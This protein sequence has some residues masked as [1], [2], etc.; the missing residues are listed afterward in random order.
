MVDAV[1]DKEGR[2][3]VDSVVDV[4][5]QHDSRKG[6]RTQQ[7]EPCQPPADAPKR[8]GA[9]ER[10][11]RV[12]GKKLVR[13]EEGVGDGRAEVAYIGDLG[14]AQMRHQRKRRA[15]EYKE[16]HRVQGKGDAVGVGQKHHDAY[17]HNRERAVDK[18]TVDL[19]DGDIGENDVG[20]RGACLVGGL[21]Y[22]PKVDEQ[23]AGKRGQGDRHGKAAVPVNPRLAGALDNQVEHGTGIILKVWSLPTS[24][25]CS[26]STATSYS[27]RWRVLRGRYSALLPGASYR[28]DTSTRCRCL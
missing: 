28:S 12:G 14:R 23:R 1:G 5:Q 24:S 22:R 19:E 13:A 7:V 11:P 2:K 25:L 15:D 16:R 9:E 3:D 10:H 20:D 6:D 4:A 21:L 17:K 8:Q 26:S 27:F 18:K